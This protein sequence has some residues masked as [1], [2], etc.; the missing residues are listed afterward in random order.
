MSIQ[1]YGREALTH[2]PPP[3]D[4]APVGIVTRHSATL[5]ASTNSQPDEILRTSRRVATPF[6]LTHT[7][8]LAAMRKFGNRFEIPG[9]P[10]DN[11][12]AE[13]TKVLGLAIQHQLL[14]GHDF[15]AAFDETVRKLRGPFSVMAE[16][17][18]MLH[19]ARDRRGACDMYVGELPSG[20]LVASSER[21]SIEQRDGIVTLELEPGTIAR[22]GAGA[23]QCTRWAFPLQKLN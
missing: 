15:E 9:V 5:Q 6:S 1:T 23:I 13:N 2:L 22:I 7:G 3:Y 10:D 11:T 4:F 18:G 17:D 21:Q 20:G 12:Q 14:L 19:V 8:L 16:Q